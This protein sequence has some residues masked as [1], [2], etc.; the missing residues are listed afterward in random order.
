VSIAEWRQV[1]ELF[2]RMESYEKAFLTLKGLYDDLQARLTET[3][4]RLDDMAK[5]PAA[6]S[7]TPLAAARR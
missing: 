6:I 7:S 4:V 1:Q 5:R 2:G 3:E